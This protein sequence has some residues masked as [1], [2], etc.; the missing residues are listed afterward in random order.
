MNYHKFKIKKFV[1]SKHF[2]K[3]TPKLYFF[4]KKKMK[5]ILVNDPI[6]FNA[7]EKSSVYINLLDIQLKTLRRIFSYY[8]NSYVNKMIK[9]F[10]NTYKPKINYKKKITTKF[11]NNIVYS[12][13]SRYLKNNNN[14]LKPSIINLT[15]RS[16]LS[17]KQFTKTIKI[18]LI[19]NPKTKFKPSSNFFI[20]ILGDV[21]SK[22]HRGN[23]IR[24]NR[25]WKWKM[26]IMKS[27]LSH[28]FNNFS[29]NFNLLNFKP[30][31]QCTHISFR[32]E[33][34][35]TNDKGNYYE[36]SIFPTYGFFN[37][38]KYVRNE[39]FQEYN[40]FNKQKNDT[41]SRLLTSREVL[42]LPANID[43]SITTNSFDV[44]HS[45][46]VPGLGIKMDCV[47]GRAT[48]HTFLFELYGLFF[49]QCAEICGRFHHHMPI[50]LAIVHYEMFILWW[51]N[52]AK[53]KFIKKKKPKL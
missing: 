50:Q 22:Y 43:I 8:P 33:R 44:V 47:P 29:I 48:H 41:S 7:K 15:Y 45:W 39:Y 34:I 28:S 1:E 3:K 19:N 16:S 35:G 5:K 11:S 53:K 6:K 51:N 25:K 12:S 20:N 27:G 9:V 42:V 21:N 2:K 36:N 26:A 37:K 23:N 10:D 17:F 52:I 14:E 4:T 24:V 31:N 49:G 40:F 30:Y 13:L 46:F 18:I 38:E 32:T